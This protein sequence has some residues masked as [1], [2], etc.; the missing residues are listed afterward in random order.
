MPVAGEKCAPA[1]QQ[2]MWRATGS[3]GGHDDSSE[4]SETRN[5][6]VNPA[7]GPR[8]NVGKW[9]SFQREEFFPEC[10]ETRANL[11]SKT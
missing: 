8:G 10:E 9:F 4:S 1:H 7:L 3:H 5:L 2:V 11:V 6:S